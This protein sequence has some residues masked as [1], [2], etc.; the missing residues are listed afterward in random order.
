MF[1]SLAA[2]VC[3]WIAPRHPDCAPAAGARKLRAGIVGLML[4]GLLLPSPAASATGPPAANLEVTLPAGR[5]FQQASEQPGLGFDCG[6]Q[7]GHGVVLRSL[8][9][10]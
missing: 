7:S 6:A 8:A 10:R 4:V 5:H 2:V 1:A 3:G 9:I